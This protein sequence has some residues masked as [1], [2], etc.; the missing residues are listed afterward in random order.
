[1]ESQ[2]LNIREEL[3]KKTT[4]YITLT[5]CVFAPCLCYLSNS[6]YG[7][8]GNRSCFIFIRN[9]AVSLHL[10]GAAGSLLV[11]LPAVSSAAAAVPAA[12]FSPVSSGNSRLYSPVVLLTAPSVESAEISA[13]V[14]FLAQ[15]GKTNNGW[16]MKIELRKHFNKPPCGSQSSPIKCYRNTQNISNYMFV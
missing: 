2:T 3:E 6:W 16:N 12:P 14:L 8:E 4:A 15:P 7:Y 5:E 9:A 13:A 1:M 10:H 11:L